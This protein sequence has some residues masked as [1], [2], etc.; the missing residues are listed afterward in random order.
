MGLEGANGSF[1]GIE[2][3]NIRRYELVVC[4]PHFCDGMFVLSAGFIVQDLKVNGVA[5]GAEVLHDGIIRF[6]SMFVFAGLEWGVQDGVGITMIHN[7]YVLIATAGSDGK[8]ATVISV[9]LADG[10]DS[11]LD[12]SS[13][14]GRQWLVV[15]LAQSTFLIGGWIGSRGC[16]GLDLG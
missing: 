9:Q 6:N 7:H 15:F 11:N 1:S 12:F 10:L 8:A 3:I 5:S 16:G 14:D 4:F 2:M 13:L